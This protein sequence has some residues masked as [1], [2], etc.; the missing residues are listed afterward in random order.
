MSYTF[1]HQ[2][3]ESFLDYLIR[4]KEWGFHTFGSPDEGRNSLGPLDHLKKEIVEIEKDNDPFEWVDLIIL[5]SDG[6]LRTQAPG[7][8]QS[9][10]HVMTMAVN[11]CPP[12]MLA[13]HVIM[14]YSNLEAVKK[15]VRVVE[16][17]PNDPAPWVR[18]CATAIC[19][20]ATDH[21]VSNLLPMLFAKQEKNALRNWPDW[22]NVPVGQA[23]EHVK[24][25]HD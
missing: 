6:L 24:G 18:L 9:L 25:V 14:P 19:G 21:G 22:R 3:Q 17:F 11:M 7:N 1:N 10:V 20:F 16:A 4:H 15:A 12:P 13:G 8:K 5:S 2:R 23:I